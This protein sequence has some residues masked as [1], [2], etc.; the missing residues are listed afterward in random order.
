MD[1][2][3]TNPFLDFGI[4]ISRVMRDKKRHQGYSFEDAGI[5]SD[6]FHVKKSAFH[7]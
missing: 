3:W 1:N 6:A 2:L 5:E 7:V 4:S